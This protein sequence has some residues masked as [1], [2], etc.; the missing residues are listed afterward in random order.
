MTEYEEIM[1]YTDGLDWYDLFRRVYYDNSALNN[2]K[3]GSR[4]GQVMIANEERTYI[5]GFT[6]D[7]YTPWL[8]N[9]GILGSPLLGSGVSDYANRADVR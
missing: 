5:R 2:L 4:L 1:S 7:E 9:R 8:K 6:H 3:E